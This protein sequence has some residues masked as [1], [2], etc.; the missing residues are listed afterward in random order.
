MFQDIITSFINAP[1]WLQIFNIVAIVFAVCIFITDLFIKARRK[2]KKAEA[3]K[4][5]WTAPGMPTVEPAD[6]PLP[7]DP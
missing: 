7:F 1:L 5:A 6:E 2:K 4:A 3:K